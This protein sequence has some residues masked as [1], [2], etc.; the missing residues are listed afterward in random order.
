MSFPKLIFPMQGA[1]GSISS[2]ISKRKSSKTGSF[3]GP[4]GT[5]VNI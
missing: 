3:P 2:H 1:E 4:P 5:F